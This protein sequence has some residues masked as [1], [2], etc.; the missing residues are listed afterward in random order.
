[1]QAP[2]AVLAQYKGPSSAAPTKLV[3]SI[4]AFQDDGE[5][6]D[7]AAA[8]VF[9][10][11]RKPDRDKPRAIDTVLEKLRAE[12][13]VDNTPSH[14]SDPPPLGSMHPH[15]SNLSN[16]PPDDGSATERGLASKG[17]QGS[18]DDGDPTTTNLYLGNIAPS[19]DEALLMREF[20]R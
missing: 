18:H 17:L 10:Q 8:S 7:E 1:M 15:L 5:E 4:K 3:A 13:A 2:T 20:G 19:V 16:L 6:E 11:S 9:Q 12:P 14:P